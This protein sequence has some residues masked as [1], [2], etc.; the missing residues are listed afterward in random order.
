[1]PTP[2]EG[3]TKESSEEAVQAAISKTIEQLVGEGF[4]QDQAIAIAFNQAKT[5]TGRELR[6]RGPRRAR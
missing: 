4:E 1:M 6:T 2:A 3:L 5:A